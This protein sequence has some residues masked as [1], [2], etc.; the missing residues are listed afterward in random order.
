MLSQWHVHAPG[1]ARDVQAHPRLAVVAVWDEEPARGA[2]WARELA[3]PFY[4]ELEAV[5]RDPTIDGVLVGTP[6]AMH[7]EVIMQ[8]VAAGKHV[9]SEKILALTAD[10]CAA[11]FAAA[12]ANHVALLLSLPRLSH[13]TIVYAQQAIR[14]GLL[15]DLTCIRCRD[16]HNG[17]VPGPG[18][19][20]GWLPEAF[21]AEDQTGGGALIDLGAHPIYV[22]NRLAGPVQAVTARLGSYYH[23]GVDDNAVVVVEYTSGALGV[24]E[25]GFVSSGSPFQL[26][27]YGT[28]GTLLVEDATLRIRSTR[29]GT[30]D[31]RTPTLP[32]ALPMPL[33]QWVGHIEQG[34]A[35]PL[36]IG[37]DDM[38][39]LT[40]VNVTARLSH[41]Q[42]RRI[43]WDSRKRQKAPTWR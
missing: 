4:A 31:W 43:A 14:E 16:A 32:P 17:A 41:E 19:P 34:P 26:Q 9:F 36:G 8:A 37:R 40:R 10:D 23:R 29:F 22:T 42:G 27:L 5:L 11:I 15:G 1:Y 35:V 30:E 7:R 24:I 38:E 20:Q 12:D 13:P 18:Q 21:F 2:A 33:D 6:T 39:R 3:V 28:E 25:T